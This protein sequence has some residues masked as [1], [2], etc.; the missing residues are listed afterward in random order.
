MFR[1][2]FL[3]HADCFRNKGA[4]FT[5]DLRKPPSL[6]DLPAFVPPRRDVRAT[7]ARALPALGLLVLFTGLFIAGGSVAFA[8]YDAR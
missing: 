6:V 3:W 2:K 7:V 4:S 8:R 1:L 5:A